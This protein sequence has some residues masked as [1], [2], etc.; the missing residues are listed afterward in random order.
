LESQAQGYQSYQAAVNGK[1]A[2]SKELGAALSGKDVGL[3]MSP[4]YTWLARLTG[5]TAENIQAGTSFL[6]AFLLS[7][8]ASFAGFILLRIRGETAAVAG[9]GG[10][11]QVTVQPP[12][13]SLDKEL[14]NRLLS[15]E[16]LDARVAALVEKRLAV[17]APPA[18]EAVAVPK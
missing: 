11:Y 4:A 12:T 8:W 14:D 17:I 3:A 2:A 18:T 1:A 9:G 10:D 5:I 6:I 16:E 7:I 15:H 13:D